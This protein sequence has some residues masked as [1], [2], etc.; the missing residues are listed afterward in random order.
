M[1]GN[2]N[3]SFISWTFNLESYCEVNFN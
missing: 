1:R 2:G 3:A